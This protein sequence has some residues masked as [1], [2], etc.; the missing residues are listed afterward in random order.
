MRDGALVDDQHA[1]AH[2]LGYDAQGR[3]AVLLG[4]AIVTTSIIERAAKERSAAVTIIL[5]RGGN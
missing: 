2:V 4:L 3:A 1:V 5:P